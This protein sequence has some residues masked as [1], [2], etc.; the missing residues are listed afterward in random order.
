MDAVVVRDHLERGGAYPSPP[1]SRFE[2]EASLTLTRLD[3]R[4]PGEIH[5]ND[6]ITSPG[7]NVL[8]LPL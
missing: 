3:E 1:G 2:A 6:Y 5:Q 8:V 7:P 4:I